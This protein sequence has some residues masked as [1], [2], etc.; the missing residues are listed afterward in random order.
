MCSCTQSHYCSV[1]RALQYISLLL[2]SFPSRLRT[3]IGIKNLVDVHE[4]CAG[5]L[6][7]GSSPQSPCATEIVNEHVQTSRGHRLQ[8]PMGS[9][10]FHE[11]FRETN[12]D[13]T[14]E[15]PAPD[16][17]RPL[18]LSDKP[19][20]VLRE[21]AFEIFASVYGNT[22]QRMDRQ[23]TLRNMMVLLHKVAVTSMLR[24]VLGTRGRRSC[25]QVPQGPKL[26]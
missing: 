8:V 5:K 6:G 11:I 26:R 10:Y 12:I 24:M 1:V 7:V 17:A 16:A 19:Q 18:V 20:R 3:V 13:H 4:W 21:A 22:Q 9:L 14:K 23:F 15:P 25:S 2:G